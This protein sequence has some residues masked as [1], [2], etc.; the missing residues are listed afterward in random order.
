MSDDLITQLR[1]RGLWKAC[2]KIERQA[3]EIERLQFEVIGLKYLVNH[4]K[5]VAFEAMGYPLP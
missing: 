1:L 3:T 5:R 4:W 2:D